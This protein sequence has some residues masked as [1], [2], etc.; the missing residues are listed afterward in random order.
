MPVEV[1]ARFR[2]DGPGPLAAL[3]AAP[4]LG[5]AVLGPARTAEVLDRYVDTDDGRLA[6]ERWACRMREREGSVRVSL[7]GPAG[8][9]AG[10]AWR[11]RRPELEGPA[12]ASLDPVD[13]PP[14]PAR[15]RVEALAGGKRIRERLQVRQERTERAV[16][17]DGGTAL[18][19]LSLDRVRLRA[20]DRDLGELFM[21][22]LE[23]HEATPAAEAGLDA[24]ADAL[25]AV[26]GL[27]P[28]PSTKLDVALARLDRAP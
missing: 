9:P 13:W 11:H 25:A 2:A 14:S 17:I 22:E 16:T 26:P 23:L 7:K 6:R 27:H 21:V 8:G 24:M 18:G 20:G 1:E 19:T 28:E 12:T 15:D 10:D 4:R 3:A 5:D